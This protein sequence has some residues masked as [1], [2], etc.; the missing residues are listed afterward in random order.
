M[1][2]HLQTVIVLDSNIFYTLLSLFH[3]LEPM[4]NVQTPTSGPGSKIFFFLNPGPQGSKCHRCVRLIPVP[5]L[6]LITVDVI[7]SA[8]FRDYTSI[9]EAIWTVND[10]LTIN[11][12]TSNTDG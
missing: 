7:E 1:Y 4:E 8:A 2:F 10:S 3:L 12:T 6:M 11:H 9:Q 5:S